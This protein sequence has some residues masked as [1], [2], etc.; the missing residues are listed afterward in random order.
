[1]KGG[2]QDGRPKKK[3]GGRTCVGVVR[4]IIVIVHRSGLGSFKL[5]VFDFFEFD[6]CGL[7][8]GWR[9]SGFGN[10]RGMWRSI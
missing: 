2:R 3:F 6:H 10:L 4:R 9:E 7:K 8:M 1:M 5:G